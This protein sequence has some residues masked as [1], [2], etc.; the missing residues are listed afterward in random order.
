MAGRGFAD[1]FN[2]LKAV[3]GNWIDLGPDLFRIIEMDTGGRDHV[4]LHGVDIHTAPVEHSP[5][6]VAFRLTGPGGRRLVYSGDTDTSA[7]LVE[8]ASGAD[9]LI[10]ESAFPEA[11]KTGGT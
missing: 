9:L 3:Y 11:L 6:S 1:F 10:C 5:Q 7:T 2:R 8:L 4:R